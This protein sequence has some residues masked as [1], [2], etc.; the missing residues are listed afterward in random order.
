MS[1]PEL[2]TERQEEAFD[3]RRQGHAEPEEHLPALTFASKLREHRERLGLSQ[4]ALSRKAGL[5]HSY[6]NRLENKTGKTTSRRSYNTFFKVIDALN[7]DVYGKEAR[8][9]GRLRGYPMPMRPVVFV[10]PVSV[11]TPYR[12]S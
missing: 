7:L 1:Y 4:R 11:H 5:N 6:I 12:N 8:E 3:S 2:E 9:L 10:N